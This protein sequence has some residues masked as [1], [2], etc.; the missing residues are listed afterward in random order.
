M[1]VLRPL[2]K[3]VA[4]DC[5]IKNIKYLCEDKSISRNVVKEKM[6]YINH[7]NR[8]DHIDSLP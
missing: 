1:R 8:Q 6:I 3:Q 5:C 2:Y 4:I 7:D